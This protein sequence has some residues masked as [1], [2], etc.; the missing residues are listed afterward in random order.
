M[1]QTINAGGKNYLVNCV[2]VGNPHCVVMKDELDVEEI[3]Q[4]G[5]FLENPAELTKTNFKTLSGN[6]NEYCKQT[7]PPRE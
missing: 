5:T 6:A 4:Y 7:A 3:K 2:S 1:D